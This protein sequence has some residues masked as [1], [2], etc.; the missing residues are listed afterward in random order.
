VQDVRLFGRVVRALDGLPFEAL[1]RDP[2]AAAR[3]LLRHPGLAV[4]MALA[5][6]RAHAGWSR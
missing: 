1:D 4:R 2:L 6:P 3:R 5:R